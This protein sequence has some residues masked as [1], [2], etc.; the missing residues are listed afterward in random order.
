MSK[1]NDVT[2]GVVTTLEILVSLI[3]TLTESTAVL[4]STVPSAQ[5]KS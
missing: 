2:V 5:V 4:L 3:T 1:P